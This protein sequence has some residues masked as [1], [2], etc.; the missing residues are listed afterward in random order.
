[1]RAVQGALSTPMGA[2]KTY[3]SKVRGNATLKC[4]AYM[5]FLMKEAFND[6]L[7][8]LFLGQAQGHQLCQLFACNFTDGCFVNKFC[9]N[10]VCRQAGRRRNRCAVHNNRIALG[11]AMTRRIAV[12]G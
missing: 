5:L 3:V 4:D 11:M 10:M 2:Y 9:I 7:F 6:I 12:H 1:M 8:R